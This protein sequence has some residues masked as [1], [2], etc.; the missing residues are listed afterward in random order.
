LRWPCEPLDHHPTP[1]GQLDDVGTVLEAPGGALERDH[2]R[3]DD[4]AESL[5]FN[6][7]WDRHSSSS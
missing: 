5:K 2:L 6:I 4:R 1:I 3:P 7:V